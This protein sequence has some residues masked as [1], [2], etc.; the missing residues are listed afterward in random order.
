MSVTHSFAAGSVIAA[1]EVN[2]NFTDV[3]NTVSA[4]TAANLSDNAGITSNQLSDRFAIV[5]ET[6]PLTGYYRDHNVTTTFIAHLPDNTT[7]GGV[8]VL[9]KYFTIRPGRACY[10][11]GISV[12]ATDITVGTGTSYPRVYVQHNG[13]TLGGGGAELRADA[14]NYYL[15]N[16][17]PFDN[18]LI[19]LSNN[20]YIQIG[21]GVSVSATDTYMSRCSVT[22]TYKMELTA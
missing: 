4:L 2:T 10:I 16:S 20:D 3:L 19:S 14:T 22:I 9:R 21:L 18:P 11:V 17:D 12:Y 5:T 6:I 15:R 7:D 1:D 13:T 8:E